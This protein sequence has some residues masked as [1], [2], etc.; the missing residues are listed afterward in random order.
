MLRPRA[1]I[2]S[3]TP[4][5]HEFMPAVR[6]RHTSPLWRTSGLAPGGGLG[7]APWRGA[8]NGQS[9][10]GRVRSAPVTAEP[11]DVPRRRGVPV[12]ADRV[13][14]HLLRATAATP[15]PDPHPHVREPGE[16][17]P[18][19]GG[20]GGHLAHPATQHL[21]RRRRPLSLGRPAR[22][23]WWPRAA[24]RGRTPGS[25]ATASPCAAS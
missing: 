6:S 1:F 20:D 22:L 15:Q 2:N 18:F 3:S 7:A 17:L 16:E 10:G 13:A 9:V 8:Q 4:P 11:H 5:T 21:A 23:P 19:A 25:P 24:G 12:E 14:D